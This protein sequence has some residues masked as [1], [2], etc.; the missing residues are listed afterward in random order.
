MA[1]LRIKSDGTPG[2][3]HVIPLYDKY[4]HIV[5]GEPLK[6]VQSIIWN[7]DV[8]GRAVAW[9]C[10]KDVEIEAEARGTIDTVPLAEECCIRID[11]RGGH[12]GH[13]DVG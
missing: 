2:N 1:R 11:A 8:N 10:V 3:T 5:E 12:C 9:I 4:N 7:C 13:G 6:G